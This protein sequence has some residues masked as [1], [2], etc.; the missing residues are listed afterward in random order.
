MGAY[1]LLNNQKIKFWKVEVLN[2]EELIEELEEFKEYD[3]RLDKIQP[4]TVL[5]AHPKRGL[6]IKAKDD[7]IS[8]KEIQGQ[9]AKKMDIGEFLKGNKIQMADIFE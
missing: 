4:G 3:Y 5:Y 2:K 6:Y 1:T 7:I 9:N 8:V